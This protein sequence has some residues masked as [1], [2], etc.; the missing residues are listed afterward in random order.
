MPVN[1]RL[2][3]EEVS[4]I[5]EH[6]GAR[7]LL[8][9]PELEDSLSS[10]ECE[11]KWTIGAETDAEL[12]RYDVEPVAWEPDEDATATTTTPPA[13]PRAPKGCS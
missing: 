2:V 10:V 13:P 11:M 9:D 1:F 12:M 7:I 8:V 5:V 3:A 6:S 4:Y